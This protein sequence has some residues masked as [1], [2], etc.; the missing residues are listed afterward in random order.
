[1]EL[2]SWAVELIAGCLEDE[3]VGWLPVVRAA[4]L[5]KNE[6]DVFVVSTLLETADLMEE[7]E[8]GSVLDTLEVELVCVTDAGIL[9][10]L[11]AAV[12]VELWG[13]NNVSGKL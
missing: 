13:F 4:V 12:S 10:E 7:E 9:D 5:E 11:G 1:M 8:D 2:I 6:D 3:E